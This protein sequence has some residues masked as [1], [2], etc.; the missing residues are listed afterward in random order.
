M[1]ENRYCD[2]CG[3]KLTKDA[4]YCPGCGRKLEHID[5][6]NDYKDN[7]TVIN[8]YNYNDNSNHIQRRSCNKWVA[9]ALCFFLG[10]IGGHK[11][12][13][14]KIGLG[15]LYLCTGG[16][17]GIGVLIDLISIILKPEDTYY[18]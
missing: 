15:I 11:F 17:F 9:L 14:G 8:N 2:R 16:L 5:D 4:E 12:Y 7:T 6:Y 3:A 18:V 10:Y 13:E 1:T